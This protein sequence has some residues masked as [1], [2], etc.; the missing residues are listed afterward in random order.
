MCDEVTQVLYSEFG[1][2]ECVCELD[3]TEEGVRVLVPAADVDVYQRFLQARYAGE[4]DSGVSVR[5]LEDPNVLPPAVR[6]A[7]IA[8]KRAADEELRAL[9][10]AG[11]RLTQD[12]LDSLRGEFSG[13]CGDIEAFADADLHEVPALLRPPAGAAFLPP[14]QFRITVFVLHEDVDACVRRLAASP[15]AFECAVEF[16]VAVLGRHKE[17]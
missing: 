15:G 1:R 10:S 14:R 16:P 5:V 13:V 3:D 12:L 8:R 6:R 7:E 17:T 4:W 11:I 2:H 9:R